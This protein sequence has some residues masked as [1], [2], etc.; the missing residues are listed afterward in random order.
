MREVIGITLGCISVLS[1]GIAIGMIISQCWSLRA[2]N[3]LRKTCQQEFDRLTK[4]WD[5]KEPK[6]P[7]EPE[8]D[9]FVYTE[10]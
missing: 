2:N 10:K 3:Q 6:E 4:M 8:L 9:M 5:S 7:A 1:L